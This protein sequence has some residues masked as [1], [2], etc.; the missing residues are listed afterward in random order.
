MPYVVN[1]R[2]DPFERFMRESKMYFRW[3]ADKLWT[4]VPAQ[5]VVAEFIGTFEEY[6]PSQPSATFGPDQALQ[7]LS[8]PGRGG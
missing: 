5:G 8:S 3:F 7:M 2:Q 4:F 6:P 1:L